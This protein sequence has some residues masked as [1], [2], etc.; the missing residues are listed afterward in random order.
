MKERQDIV[1]DHL[2]E[3]CWQFADKDGWVSFKW[4]EEYDESEGRSG[5]TEGIY[6][7]DAEFSFEGVESMRVGEYHIHWRPKALAR[8]LENN[9]FHCLRT[10]ADMPKIP[11]AYET[12]HVGDVYPHIDLCVDDR[13]AAFEMWRKEGVTHWREHRPGPLYWEGG[14]K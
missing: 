10:V 14:E 7:W 4:D 13:Q 8:A 5:S 9:G 1:R 11:G 2:P 3:N 12:W 6:W